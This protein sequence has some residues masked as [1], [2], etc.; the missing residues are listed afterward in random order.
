MSF[1]LFIAEPGVSQTFQ[2]YKLQ[3]K[4]QKKKENKSHVA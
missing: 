2:F 3:N 4:Q 1:S